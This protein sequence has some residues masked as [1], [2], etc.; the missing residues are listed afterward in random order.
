MFFSIVIPLYNKSYSINR[1]IDSVLSQT[2]LDFEIIIVNDGSTDESLPIVNRCYSNEINSDII[3]VIDQSNQGVSVA[4]NNGSNLAKSDYICFLDAD[5]EWR[6]DFLEKMSML[7]A[8]FPLANLY[9]LAHMIKK[10]GSSLY[11]PK[12]GLSEGYRGYLENFFEAS[13]RGSVVKSSKVCVKKSA[14]LEIGGFPIGV[15]AGEDLY[16]WI[17][18]ALNGKVAC[19][20]SYSTIVY[21]ESDNSRASRKN[22]IPYPLVFFSENSDFQRSKALDKY[23]FVIFYKHFFN[24][25]LGLRWK[26]A[27]LRFEKYIKI[28]I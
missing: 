28:Y 4:R 11:K 26:E 25:L 3:K 10:N 12:H 7:I 1:C 17:R 19:D 13:S 9:S 21:L 22:S 23:L 16:V 14:F 15:V 18:L 2:F 5:D 8:D 27:S 20:M 6:P 24:S